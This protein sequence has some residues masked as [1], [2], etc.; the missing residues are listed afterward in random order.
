MPNS[1]LCRIA[2]QVAFLERNGARLQF[3]AIRHSLVDTGR[4]RELEIAAR[5]PTHLNQP[6]L[7]IEVSQRE[8]PDLA[9]TQTQARQDQENRIIT[10][11]YSR[12][13]ID[14]RRQELNPAGM[15]RGMVDN[16]Q[17]AMAGTHAARSLSISPR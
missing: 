13:S 7:P 9:G 17:L 12:L 1:G 8:R 2:G 6:L 16:F 14:G 15:A 11:T 5:L 3:A 10:A 4:Q